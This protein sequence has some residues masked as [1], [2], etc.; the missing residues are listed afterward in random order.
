MKT[1]LDLARRRFLRSSVA[2]GAAVVERGLPAQS[3]IPPAVPKSVDL[4]TAAQETYIKLKDVF[5]RR[6]NYWRLGQTFDTFI[7]YVAITHA[8]VRPRRWRAEG[9]KTASLDSPTALRSPFRDIFFLVEEMFL[10]C[11]RHDVQIRNGN[12]DM[13]RIVSGS[14]YDKQPSSLHLRCCCW[15]LGLL[16]VRPMQRADNRARAIA[17]D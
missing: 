11:S 17:N 1:R 8:T 13:R 4:A 14:I 15:L 2:F 16:D 5:Q 6:R 10:T 12:V 3:D 9:A 7:D